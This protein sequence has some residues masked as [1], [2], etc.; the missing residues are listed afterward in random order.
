[1]K[2]IDLSVA[3]VRDLNQA[4][5]DQTKEPTEREWLVSLLWRW[6]PVHC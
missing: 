4:L 1:M 2:T 3:S 6:R 5:H